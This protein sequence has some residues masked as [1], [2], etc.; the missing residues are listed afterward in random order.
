MVCTC[1]L[2]IVLI[3]AIFVRSV[4]VLAATTFIAGAAISPG[5]ISTF[6][7]VERLVPSLL[8]TE[9][10]TWTNS[11]MI[12][13]YAAGTSLSGLFIDS[14]GTSVSFTLPVA[15]AWLASLLALGPTLAARP[16]PATP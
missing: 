11:G 14:L 13:G 8:L 16:S 10:L 1:I 12:L 6:A 5:L 7:L 9:A 3:P 4:P 15:G 2:G